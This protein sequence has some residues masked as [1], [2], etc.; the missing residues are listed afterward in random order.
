MVTGVI[1]HVIDELERSTQVHAIPRQGVFELGSGM[2]QHRAELRR[3]FEQ[4]GGLPPDDGEVPGL[5]QV[6]IA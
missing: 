3:G 5:V 4:L 1:E 2:P 6:G